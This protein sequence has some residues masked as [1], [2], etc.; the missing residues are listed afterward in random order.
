MSWL[1]KQKWWIQDR[2]CG[3]VC[4]KLW[5][6]RRF[7]RVYCS[8]SLKRLMIS[9]GKTSHWIKGYVENAFPRTTPIETKLPN[10]EEETQVLKRVHRKWKALTLEL[11][12]MKGNSSKLKIG[13][14]PQRKS[15]ADLKRLVL[16]RQLTAP[17]IYVLIYSN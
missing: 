10:I 15:I 2:C 16:Y 5:S 17:H 13:R 11:E 12:R 8:I 9:K 6:Q 1:A 3:F 7:K 14:N 4:K